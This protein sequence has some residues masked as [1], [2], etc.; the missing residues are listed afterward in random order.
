MTPEERAACLAALEAADRAAAALRAVLAA[1]E[2]AQAPAP[3][4]V[5]LAHAVR[6]WG[7]TKDAALKRARRGAGRK[8]D[9]RWYVPRAALA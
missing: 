5:P 3:D 1:E 8:V 6:A 2:A 7:I 9:G 4:L